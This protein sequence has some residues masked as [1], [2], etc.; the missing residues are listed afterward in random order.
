MQLESL[1]RSKERAKA[2]HHLTEAKCA[3]N[4]HPH[5]LVWNSPLGLA[6]R[7]TRLDGGQVNTEPSGQRAAIHVPQL[8]WHWTC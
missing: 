3:I 1:E 5:G 8:G 6:D 2:V 7:L 4:K